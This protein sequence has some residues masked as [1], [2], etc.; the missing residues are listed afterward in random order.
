MFANDA[1]VQI[2]KEQLLIKFEMLKEYSIEEVSMASHHLVK[3]RETTWPAMPAI[4]EFVK[5]IESHGPKSI[6][7]E[8]RAEM[9][10]AIVIKKL[11]YDGRNGLIDFSDPITKSIMTD[12]WP[13]NSWASTITES[14]ITWWKKD[15][16]VLYKSYGKHESAGLLTESPGG[17]MIPAGE[18]KQLANLSNNKM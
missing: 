9:Q 13:Y 11:K 6:G 12:R 18:L 3:Y 7:I 15:F 2:T 4:P 5:V 17:K 16:I 1:G 14:E 10:A 8:E